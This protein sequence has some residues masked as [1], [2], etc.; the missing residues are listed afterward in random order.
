M[1]PL[2]ETVPGETTPGVAELPAAAG[3]ATG[4]APS[5]GVVSPARG[6][7]GTVTGP[8]GANEYCFPAWARASWYWIEGPAATPVS[9]PFAV[10]GDGVISV[11]E[12]ARTMAS[13]I[14]TMP[15]GMRLARPN[16]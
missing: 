1:F 2:G 3:K 4:A 6:R 7:Y 11:A 16:S 9:P 10:T 8:P 5:T 13:P 12:A 15:R 14:P